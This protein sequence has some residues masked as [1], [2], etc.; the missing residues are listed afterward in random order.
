MLKDHG[1]SSRWRQGHGEGPGSSESKKSESNKWNEWMNEY[2]TIGIVGKNC[3]T[4]SPAGSLQ[5]H[6]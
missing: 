2:H 1:S 6:R 5:S 4:K 3:A